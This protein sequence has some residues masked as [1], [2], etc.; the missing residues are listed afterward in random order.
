MRLLLD[1]HVFIWWAT[2]PEKLSQSALAV[3]EN[4]KNTLV[5][6]SVSIW[7]MQIKMQLGKLQLP[8]TLK[9]LITQHQKI[10]MLKILNISL[11]HIY[12]LEVLPMIHRDPFD[13]L[14]ICQALEDKIVLVS[15]DRIFSDYDVDLLW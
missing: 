14:L 4:D 12:K 15:K 1:T 6:S 11:D 13:R 7:E 8:Y 5:L 3:C 9:N 10:N 2:S